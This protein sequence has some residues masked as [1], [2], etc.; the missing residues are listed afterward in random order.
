MDIRKSFFACTILLCLGVA[1]PV[2]VRAAALGYLQVNVLN[3]EATVYVNGQY[4]GT[5][6]PDKAL[7]IMQGYPV[8]SVSVIVEA[9]GFKRQSEIYQIKENAWTQA[10][11]TL[12]PGRQYSAPASPP[13]SLSPPGASGGRVVQPQADPLA[14]LLERCRTYLNRNA[15]T[16]PVGRN[17]VECYNQALQLQPGSSEALK[18][19]ASVEDKYVSWASSNIRRGNLDKARVYL[20][21]L[22]AINP[23]SPRVWALQSSIDEKQTEMAR[24]APPA[25][26]PVAQQTPRAP[27]AQPVAQ[28][29]IVT[30]AMA[31]LAGIEMVQ[32]P[33]GCFAMGS[34]FSETGR[35]AD[36]Q[37]HKVCVAGFELSK[38]E[39]TLEQFALFVRATGY[40]TD[41]ENNTDNSLGCYAEGS[42]Q[43]WRYVSGRDWRNPG[44][45]QSSN[46]P[47]VCVSWLDALAYIDWLNG[48]SGMNFRLPTEAEW[49]YAAR[50]NSSAA[51]FWGDSPTLACSYSNVADKD[52]FKEYPAFVPHD[53]RDGHVYT[54][55]VGS[56]Q[57]NSFGLY[58]ML[59]NVSE[60]VCSYYRNVYNGAETKCARAS[61][62]GLRVNRGG[63][64][65]TKPDWARAAVRA[66]LRPRGRAD[67]VGFRLA[68]DSSG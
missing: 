58:D 25:A 19:L 12:L 7:N 49:E 59:G 44:F 24:A 68:R 23:D 67:S 66:R 9:E 46:Q 40:R 50:A 5:A 35:D 62:K 57:P 41:A 33:A 29:V 39:I 45:S 21:R 2:G 42:D 15:L 36:E 4:A 55:P 26:E 63:A 60:W 65:M 27:A 30:P 13:A 28:P 8:G 22:M 31:A 53:C 61:S 64:W 10:V 56:F 51:R 18:G 52:S 1:F 11:F 38:H 3:A 6:A 20:N 43:G 14:S 48:E 34:P 47:V 54:A 32:I 16:T 17:A 37:Q